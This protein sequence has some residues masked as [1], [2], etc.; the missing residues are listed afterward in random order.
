M[1]SP[2]RERTI[3]RTIRGWTTLAVT[4]ATAAFGL[5]VVAPAAGRL[6]TA[7][8]LTQGG[9]LTCTGGAGLNQTMAA[10]TSGT[11][12]ANPTT[13]SG[14]TACTLTGVI[15]TG[16]SV[17]VA[18]FPLTLTAGAGNSGTLT[19]SDF[20]G[21]PT[22]ATGPNFQN[23]GTLKFAHIGAT[24]NPF[25]FHVAALTNL[26]GGTVTTDASSDVTFNYDNATVAGTFVNQGAITVPAG[27]TLQVGAGNCTTGIDFT[28][29]AGATV[30]IGSGGIFDVA[31]GGLDIEGGTVTGAPITSGGNHLALSFGASVPPASTGTIDFSG[32]SGATLSGTIASGWTVDTTSPLA[33]TAGA[34]NA[35]ILEFA[36]QFTSNSLTDPGTFTNSG[37]FDDVASNIGISSPDFVNT[38]TVSLTGSQ[39]VVTFT[40]DNATTPGLFD[41]S[42]TLSVATGEQVIVGPQSCTQGVNLVTEAGSTINAVGAVTEKCGTLDLNGGAVTASGPLSVAP[43]GHATVDFAGG[44]AAGPGTAG[45]DTVDITA[46]GSTVEGTIPVGWTLTPISPTTIASGTTNA[47][48]IILPS[49]VYTVTGAGTFTNSGTVDVP[50]NGSVNLAIP[51]VINTGTMEATG[52]VANPSTLAFTYD[53]ASVA[54]TIDNSGTFTVDA[55]QTMN[56]GPV[57]CTHGEALT[58]ETGST[59]VAPGAFQV[60]CGS[61]DIAG[62]SV[63]AAGPIS[64]SP[65][66][67]VAVTFAPGLPTGTG[68]TTDTLS[69]DGAGVSFTDDIAAGWTVSTGGAG[70]SFNMVDGAANN[71]TIIL[72]GDNTF[73]GGPNLPTGTFNNNG[74][75]ESTWGAAPQIQT[76]VNT[77]TVT[78]D[79]GASLN[80]QISS[81]TND[82]TVTIASTGV[83]DAVNFTQDP[84]GTLAVA[85]NGSQIGTYRGSGGQATLGGTLAITTA[86]PPPSAPPSGS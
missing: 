27:R 33:A 41:N 29:D 67:A 24:G 78:V 32:G 40:Y 36:N 80:L 42:G 16:W 75:F 46:A 37:T 31:C 61:L 68:G 53:N 76:F 65:T 19:I 2:G 48:T 15:P 56:V 85:V 14:A 17:T 74:T 35:G 63:T 34:G 8:Q 57:S 58:E 81:V 28:N 23:E 7:G 71:G 47:G 4:A 3:S 44:L 6:T 26:T 69:V 49:N 22:T 84:A 62:G 43:V 73:G 64:L 10:G 21:S 18:Q 60:R 50:A 9:T 72:H 20:N 66:P 51:H 82:G 83:F 39:S 30:T 5:A 77:G 55:G 25:S 54:G 13:V 59:V 70:E 86:T 79:A 38:G 1:T 52:T 11:V 12:V 45:T